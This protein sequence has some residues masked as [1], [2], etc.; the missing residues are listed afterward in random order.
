MAIYCRQPTDYIARERLIAVFNGVGFFL[1]DSRGDE[2]AAAAGRFRET[3][4]SPEP[5]NDSDALTVLPTLLAGKGILRSMD[6]GEVAA[7]WRLRD[8]AHHP[9]PQGDMP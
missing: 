4:S 3:S 2:L 1:P 9:P 7:V 6:C 8:A 5:H